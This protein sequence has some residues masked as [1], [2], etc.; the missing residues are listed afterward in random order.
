MPLVESILHTDF[1][2]LRP[3]VPA[4]FD[5]CG[6]TFF[7]TLF[8]A[9]EQEQVRYCALHV[10]RGV[11]YR[12]DFAVH[13]NDVA[14]LPAIF[15]QLH[16]IG[17]YPVQCF[18][19]D[20]GHHR[21][22][23]ARVFETKPEAVLIDIIFRTTSLSTLKL[24]QRRTRQ[25]NTWAADPED[26]FD[27]LT[28]DIA[29]HKD[30]STQEQ[31]HLRSLIQRLGVTWVEKH[32]N[33]VFG[34]G[35]GALIIKTFASDF[36]GDLLPGLQEQ[37]RQVALGGP[38]R[39]LSFAI[40]RCRRKLGTYVTPQGAF[41]VFLGPDGVGKTTLLREVS[42]GI[43]AIFSSQSIYRWRP[44]VFASAPR[45][46]CLPHSKP[47]R[48]IWGSIG[49]LLFTW[50][51]FLAGYALRTR[52]KLAQDGV[53]IFDRYYHDILIDPLRYRYAGPM[54]LLTAFKKLVPPREIFFFVLDADELTVLNRKRQL[55]LE[56]IQRQRISYREFATRVSDSAI[57]KTDESVESSRAH[58]LEQLFRYLSQRLAKRNPSW[59][60]LEPLSTRPM[61][62][63][64]SAEQQHPAEVPALD[65]AKSLD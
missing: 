61:S 60:S 41:L 28:R 3:L 4:E 47:L 17:Y 59:F 13:P 54:W 62:K 39:R 42:S 26:T 30:I 8:Q 9:F 24:I 65:I 20:S 27:C 25:G 38:L 34:P 35:S 10:H 2:Q 12:T 18:E 52:W 19:L 6:Q 23:F 29:L 5:P 7:S 11:L 64:T 44:A 21:L 43:A 56:E 40:A 53:V 55:P 14:T 49:Y 37:L 36:R 57:V 32:S 48:S 63:S 1:T 50:F 46:V 16:T 51:D 15:K 58:A 45:T 31:E 22:L 33:D